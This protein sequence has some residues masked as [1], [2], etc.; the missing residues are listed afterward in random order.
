M[1]LENHKSLK[2]TPVYVSK[3]VFNKRTISVHWRYPYPAIPSLRRSRFVV[4]IGRFKNIPVL[5]FKNKV[6]LCQTGGFF[7]LNEFVSDIG[8]WPCVV[9][10]TRFSVRVVCKQ[11]RSWPCVVFDT[12]FSVR[13]VLV[14]VVFTRETQSPRPAGYTVMWGTESPL[15]DPQQSRMNNGRRRLWTR[16]PPQPCPGKEG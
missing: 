13:V 11:D 4:G 15:L 7:M 2:I 8:S 9:F 16:Q 14:V 1:P 12:R 3:Y 10:H 5:Q 6:L